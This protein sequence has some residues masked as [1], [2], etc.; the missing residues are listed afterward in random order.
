[1]KVAT[2]DNKIAGTFV[3]KDNHPDLGS[4]IANASYM[5]PGHAAGQEIGK[6]MGKYSIE[7]AKRPGYQA[8]QFNFVVTSNEKAVLLWKKL[9]FEIIGEIPDAYNYQQNGLT[10]AYIMYLKL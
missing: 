1:M 4:H 5:V 8:M 2:I 10:N 3:I 6:K 7:E 9:G